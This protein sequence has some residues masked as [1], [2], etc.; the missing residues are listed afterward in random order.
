MQNWKRKG[1]WSQEGKQRG[2]QAAVDS[3]T[4]KANT[5]STCIMMLLN[6]EQ[7]LAHTCA[8]SWKVLMSRGQS[9]RA[10]HKAPLW[11]RM[12]DENP[13]QD[14][15]T[16]SPSETAENSS[17]HTILCFT[18]PRVRVCVCVKC[19]NV[20]MSMTFWKAVYWSDCSHGLVR[21]KLPS[22]A[23]RSNRTT[24][25]KSP[26]LMRSIHFQNKTLFWRKIMATFYTWL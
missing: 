7:G 25:R 16:G 22:P 1:V 14:P 12:S 13:K 17:A 23:I 18:G 21:P 15:T 11:T 3:R 24:N 5:R 10:K 6:K 19:I 9:F 26:L 8:H 4:A 20:V 2:P